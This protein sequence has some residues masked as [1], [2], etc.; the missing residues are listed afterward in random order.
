MFAYDA[1][2]L[3]RFQGV[4]G[5]VVV[6]RGVVN[7]P[8]PAGLA[9]SFAAEQHRVRVELGERSLAELPSIAAWRRA[10]SA[11]GVEPTKYRNA[12][13]ALL[14]RLTKK[15]DIPSISTLVDLGNLVSIR[16][17]LPVAVFDLAALNGGLTVRFATGTERFDDLGGTE[18]DHPVA[19]EVVFVDDGGEVGARR[20][21]WRQSTSSATTP[22]TT[23]TLITVEAHHEG[24]EADIRQ[25]LGSFASLF[26]EHLPGVIVDIAE[27][28]PSRPAYQGE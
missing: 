15:G 9:A 28:G 4:R 14:R 22:T 17:R 13:E 10:F 21:C 23:D 18:A 16:H 1:A 20:W 24:G 5:G 26:A 7:G 12:A 6:A 27:L 11:F 25:A 2:V 19:G 8:S 3:E